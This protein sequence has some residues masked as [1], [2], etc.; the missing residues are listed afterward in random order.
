G[1]EQ[2]PLAEVDDLL[3]ALALIGELALVDQQARIG[4]AGENLLADL[5]E[6]DGAVAEVA[7]TEPQDE[8]RGRELARY[9]DLDVAQVGGRQL[10]LRDDDRAVAR[11]HRGAVRQQDVALLH[12][13]VRGE[14]DGGDL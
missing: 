5:V 10:L 4:A 3:Q 11:A 8:E 13:R 14:R 7:E 1:L 12:E 2:P 9:Q 6:R